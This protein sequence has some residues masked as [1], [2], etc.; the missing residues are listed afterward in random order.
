MLGDPTREGYRYRRVDSFWDDG[1]LETRGRS[2]MLPFSSLSRCCVA[3]LIIN[4]G[5]VAVVLSS[6]FKVVLSLAVRVR[7][8]NPRAARVPT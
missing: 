2:C 6:V 4:R 8:T 3:H 1:K 7:W 5:F